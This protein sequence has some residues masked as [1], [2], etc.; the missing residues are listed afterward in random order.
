MK[1]PFLALILL[2]NAAIFSQS[3]VPMVNPVQMI[4]KHI[5]EPE[6]RR[7]L[8]LLNPDETG[9]LGSEFHNPEK[10]FALDI[11]YGFISRITFTPGTALTANPKVFALPFNLSWQSTMAQY[12]QTGIWKPAIEDNRLLGSFP[13]VYRDQ[14]A[15]PVTVALEFSKSSEILEK[16]VFFAD[17][18]TLHH[19]QNQIIRRGFE[20]EAPFESSDWPVFLTSKLGV[21]PGRYLWAWLNAPHSVIVRDD[22]RG[23]AVSTTM[24]YHIR[25]I[26]FYAE[27]FTGQLPLQLDF[28]L[29]LHQLM[30]RFGPRQNAQTS[31][32]YHVFNVSRPGLPP[33]ELGVNYDEDN[34]ENISYYNL[35]LKWKLLPEWTALFLEDGIP[36]NT[37]IRD[38]TRIWVMGNNNVNSLKGDRK[39]VVTDHGPDTLYIAATQISGLLTGDLRYQE[40]IRSWVY[41]VRVKQLSSRNRL[42]HLLPVYQNCIQQALGSDFRM[43]DESNEKNH[44]Y[45]FVKNPSSGFSSADTGAFLSAPKP[46]EEGFLTISLRF[47]N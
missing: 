30:S 1:T 32:F 10:G 44:I 28:Q 37:F 7:V 11:E 22:D 29:P 27:E 36:D 4:G 25:E 40:A 15:T 6:M 41:D 13:T 5:D 17:L 23:V 16:I 38:L 46:P 3:T 19:Q 39:T 42:S 18:R 47:V 8:D 20:N 43:V 14:P 26:K 24:D 31:G 21:F 45:R 2:F 34:P 35:R 9:V 33:M 12:L